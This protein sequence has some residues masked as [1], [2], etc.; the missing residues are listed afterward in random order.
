[1]KTDLCFLKGLGNQDSTALIA[2]RV[3]KEIMRYKING[4]KCIPTQHICKLRIWLS[5]EF[6]KAKLQTSS[7]MVLSNS[8]KID[9]LATANSKVLDATSETASPLNWNLK[10]LEEEW[11]YQIIFPYGYT[12]LSIMVDNCYWLS[13]E[14]RYLCRETLCWPCRQSS[15]IPSIACCIYLSYF[16]LFKVF[17]QRLSS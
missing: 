7:G 15:P 11:R 10:I 14:K 3:P 1:M 2:Q 8:W 16:L 12:S 13:S 17:Q 6:Q 5:E 9:H 4:R